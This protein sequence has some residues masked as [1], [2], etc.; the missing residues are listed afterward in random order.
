MLET[1]RSRKCMEGC[2]YTAHLKPGDQQKLI[3][4]FGKRCI[5]KCRLTTK[6]VEALYDTGEQVSLISESILENLN[7]TEPLRKL[8]HQE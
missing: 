2:I 1:Q 5:V 8:L 3:K 6:D 4:L 7:I